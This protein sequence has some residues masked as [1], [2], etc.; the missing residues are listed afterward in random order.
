MNQHAES[1]GLLNC[2]SEP[3]T[4]PVFPP[5][6]QAASPSLGPPIL[7]AHKYI[8]RMHGG[9]QPQLLKASD[10]HYYVVK[11]VNNSQR[12]EVLVNELLAA[13]LARMMGLPVPVFAIVSVGQDLINLSP[14]MVI[15]LPRTREP[16]Q[17]GFAFGSRYPD[18]PAGSRRT[19]LCE[20]NDMSVFRSYGAV[21]NSNDF[22]G[23]LVFDRWTA[24]SDRRQVVFT[25]TE[26]EAKVKKNRVNHRRPAAVCSPVAR[27]YRALMID[28]GF[29]FGFVLEGFQEH[30]T[31]SIYYDPTVYPRVVRMNSFEPWL[32]LVEGG[33][34]L[35]KLAL[36]AEQVP[37]QWLDG[38]RSF[39]AQ[40]LDGLQN[41]RCLVRG[42]IAESIPRIVKH[43]SRANHHGRLIG[44]RANA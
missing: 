10:N 21:V 30:R 18:R 8:R 40:V 27:T 33:L 43:P 42:L 11:F 38:D 39:L 24:N 28:N 44:I 6:A 29:C 32:E 16:C 4:V 34:D 23:M 41:R 35:S 17:P 20:V 37:A 3:I 14:E 12:K 22:L 2:P 36:L 15:E 19:T 13:E 1:S 7:R 26:P 31:S 5:I 9:S 25:Q